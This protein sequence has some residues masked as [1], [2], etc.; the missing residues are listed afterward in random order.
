MVLAGMVRDHVPFNQILSGDSCTTATR[1]RRRSRRATTTTT[2]V[3]DGDARPELQRATDLARCRSRASIGAERRDGRRDHDAAAAQAFF[4]A[5]TN[6]AMFRFT[7]INHLCMDMEQ[8]HDTSVIPDR[9]R[10]TSRA[11]WRRQPRVLE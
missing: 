1:S 8:V 9:I 7:L 10:Q 6:R 5:G 3:R 4:I 2:C 11:A